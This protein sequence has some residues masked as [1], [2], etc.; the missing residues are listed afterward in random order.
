MLNKTEKNYLVSA[1]VAVLITFFIIVFSE[2]AFNAALDGL[3]VWWEVV[4]PSL[5]PFFIIAEILMGLGVVHFMG[6]L[7]EPLMRPLFKVPGVG[8]FAMAMGLASGYP[9]GAKITA[10]LRRNNLCNKTEGERLVSF[11]NT[12][13][14][15]FMIGAVAVGMFHRVE[16]GIIMAGAHYVSSLIVGLVLRFYKGNDSPPGQSFIRTNTKKRRNILAYAI[17]ELL[18]AR[19]ND[20]RSL[21]ELI[22]D[23]IKESINTLLMVGG[24]IILFSV[25]TEIFIVTGIINALSSIL[26]YIFQPLGLSH[27]LIL[28]LISGFFEITNGANLAS[29]SQAP[30][31]HQV[32][33]A[34]AIIAWSGLSVHA[35]VATMVN[36]TD[37]GLKPYFFSRILQSI[38]AGIVTIFLFGP[39]YE[40]VQTTFLPLIENLNIPN[41]YLLIIFMFLGMLSVLFILSMII[42]FIQKIRVIFFHYH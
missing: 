36:D 16:L 25:I 34:N 2:E 27:T 5:L 42:Y 15:L 7:L 12:A 33:I 21:G 17:T 38:L 14:P 10:N 24:F 39:Y 9:I 37:I 41:F 6:A 22:G 29:Q 31:L 1:A 40:N 26:I 32:I 35:Q 23:S 20:G 19:K 18:E 8:A 11:T 4:F 30:I 28:P 3:K 13:D